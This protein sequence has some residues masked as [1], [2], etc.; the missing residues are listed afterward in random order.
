MTAARMPYSSTAFAQGVPLQNQQ[1]RRNGRQR[2][3]NA[4]RAARAA[5]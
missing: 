2:R 1:A 4:R 3:G 5:I